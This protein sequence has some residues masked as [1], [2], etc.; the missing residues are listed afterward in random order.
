MKYKRGLKQK[1]NFK[2]PKWMECTWRRIPCGKDNCPICGRIKRDRQRHIEKGEDPDDIKSVFEDVGRNLKEALAMIKKD[3]ERMGIDI[4]NIDNIQEPPAP[5]EF[6]LYNKVKE[7]H[8][9][10]FEIIEEAE[11][12]EDLLLLTEA[13]QD[14]SWYSNILLAKVYRQLC[15][16]WYIKNGNDY[17]EFDY[18]YTKYVLKECL[19]ILKQSFRELAS[20]YSNREINLILADE[21][22]SS[23]EKKILK[24]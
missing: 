3:A 22:L 4:T 14:L 1:E 7:W 15:N 8:D 6:P 21:E 11:K 10:V 24:I 5:E 19:K 16:K 20:P 13:A 12:A 18:Q 17:G 9:F 23:L 2:M